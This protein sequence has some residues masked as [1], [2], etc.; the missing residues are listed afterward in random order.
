[1]CAVTNLLPPKYVRK[2]S[3]IQEIIQSIKFFGPFS[4]SSW[5]FLIFETTNPSKL[6]T[7]NA[8]QK[9]NLIVLVKV[10]E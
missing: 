9:N 1:M 2:S 3:F 6:S 4:A 8:E 5:N 10:K 7:I